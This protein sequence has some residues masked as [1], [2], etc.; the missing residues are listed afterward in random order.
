MNH[1]VPIAVKGRIDNDLPLMAQVCLARGHVGVA[2]VE[3]G[4]DGRF[5]LVAKTAPGL[6]LLLVVADGREAVRRQLTVQAPGLTL[7]V[8]PVALVP[9]EWPAGVHGHLWD[10]DGQSPVHGGLAALSTG[11]GVVVGQ[12]RA[13]PD[14][15]FVIPMTCQRPLPPGDYRLDV[16]APGYSAETIQVPIAL[17]PSVTEL[18]RVHLA[19]LSPSR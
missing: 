11:K 14:G 10:E 5:E 7:D 1:S 6:H 8:G 12:T 18:G 17:E 4:A 15:A 13:D 16:S 9:V 19:P 3:A 2:A